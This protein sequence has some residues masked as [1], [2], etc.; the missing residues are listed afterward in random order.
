M[1]E[2]ETVK[3]MKKIHLQQ[4]L[5][6]RQDELHEAQEEEKREDASKVGRKLC[7][8]VEMVIWC[9]AVGI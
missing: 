3:L 6:R 8:R 2:E 1:R 4:D 7:S 5:I 9:D